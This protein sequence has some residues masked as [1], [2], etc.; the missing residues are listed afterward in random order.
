MKNPDDYTY[1]LLAR[2]VMATAG[3]VLE[4]G[5]GNGSTPMLWDLCPGRLMTYENN[6]EWIAYAKSIHAFNLFLV[7]DWDAM[8]PSPGMSRASVVFID[9]APGHRRVIDIAAWRMCADFVVIHDTEEKSYGYEYVL[10]A[11]KYRYDD[12][13]VRPWTTAV[14]MFR[15]IPT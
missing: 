6:P 2:C 15:E 11:F 10:S 3:L 8:L 12:K 7:D 5:A 14:S 13:R 4:Y 9:H 1:P